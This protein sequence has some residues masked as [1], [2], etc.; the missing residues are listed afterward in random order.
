MEN[1]SKTINASPTP[2]R[3]RRP[4]QCLIDDDA[5]PQKVLNSQ[6]LLFM[7]GVLKINLQ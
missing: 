6:L 5:S 2:V 4:F 1:T 3:P 7:C